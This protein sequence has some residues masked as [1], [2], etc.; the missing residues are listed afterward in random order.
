M[1]VLYV[2]PEV[3][4]PL[5]GGD[6]IRQ[7]HLLKN[8]AGKH[9]IDL[10]C[11]AQD[12]RERAGVE[13]MKKFWE[14]QMGTAEQ[15]DEEESKRSIEIIRDNLL[16]MADEKSPPSKQKD[17]RSKKE[18]SGDDARDQPAEKGKETDPS[19]KPAGNEKEPVSTEKEAAPEKTASEVLP[20]KQAKPE[21]STDVDET[22][23]AVD[24]SGKSDG[25]EEPALPEVVK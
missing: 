7:Y 6:H 19:E 5:H 16:K 9:E 2:C 14:G 17:R 22:D 4:F 10:L 3:P 23:N 18:R 24:D 1:K 25:A 15:L 20:E 11:F 13:E 8:L 12:E 21:S